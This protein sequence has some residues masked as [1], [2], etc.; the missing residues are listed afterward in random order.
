MEIGISTYTDEN[1]DLSDE[2]GEG[3]HL[4]K[5]HIHWDN[6][7]FTVKTNLFSHLVLKYSHICM[8]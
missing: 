8:T 5:F 2:V 7:V 4:K 1:K 6:T 3:I